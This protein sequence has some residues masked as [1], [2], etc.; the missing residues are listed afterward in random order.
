MST[1]LHI[2]GFVDL[3]VNGFIGVDFSSEA[4]TEEAF[5]HAGHALIARGTAAFLPTLIT[6][7]EARLHRN[8]KLMCA[9]LKKD[10]TLARHVPGFHLEGPFI[11][12]EPGAV[13]AHDPASVRTPDVDLFDRLFA[14][15]EGRLRLLTL[16]AEL[17]GAVEL[18]RHAVRRGAAVS[19]GHQLAGAVDLA[20]LVEAG[21]TSLTHLGNGMPNHVHRHNNPL[22]SGLAEQRLKILFIPDG[23]HLPH[24][25]IALFARAAGPDRLIA[26]SD[27]ASAAGLPP[28]TYDVLGSRAVLEPSGLLHSPEKQ[29]LVGSSSTLFACM[30][31]LHGTGLFAL[32]ELLRIGFYNPLALVGLTPQDVPTAPYRLAFSP[33]E[34]FTLA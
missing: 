27:S 10:A 18:A 33:A 16:A 14:W 3:Q 4:L 26:T 13:G 9:A 30:N 25:I 6:S 28:G 21:A 1:P 2:P 20:R 17:P 23:H 29:C 22:L 24:H 34:G 15:S 11:S 32:D 19:C 31:V 12:K 7:T 8:L 5:L